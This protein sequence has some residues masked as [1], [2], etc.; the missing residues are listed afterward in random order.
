MY[1]ILG[2]F[3]GLFD[4]FWLITSFVLFTQAL[5]ILVTEIFV[6]IYVYMFYI[7]ALEF[8][9]NSFQTVVI[10]VPFLIQYQI[11]YCSTKTFSS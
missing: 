6:Y 8:S 11:F 5:L 4:M 2:L 7:L 9:S 10:Y 1:F 3:I